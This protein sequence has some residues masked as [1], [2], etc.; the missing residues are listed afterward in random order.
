MK[1]CFLFALIALCV[2]ACH[3]AQQTP[4]D[5]QA[6]FHQIVDAA[7]AH[8]D[9]TT[10]AR[11][12]SL[13]GLR[14]I[15]EAEADFA[16]GLVSDGSRHTQ[17]AERYWTKCY[18][19]L[20]PGRDGWDLYLTVASRLSQIRMSIGDHTGALDVA[21]K[22]LR[23]AEQA[24]TLTTE[25]KCELL[26]S[27]AYCQ[28]NLH[29]DEAEQ[30][31]RQ[32]SEL[33]RQ[34]AEEWGVAAS[35]NELVFTYGFLSD[36]VSER[37]WPRVDSLVARMEALFVLCDSPWD[38]EL[39]EEYRLRLDQ[40]K[41]RILDCQDRPQEAMAL[42]EETLPKMKDWPDGLAWAARYLVSK[43]RYAEA[44]DL[45]D[46]V[47]ALLPD[48]GINNAPTLDN[49]GYHLIP[50]FYANNHAGRKEKALE[51]GERIALH[52]NEALSQ[53]KE[54]NAAELAII[55]DT[56]G[57]EMQI[58]RQRA[59]L[60]QQRLLGL[61]IAL[62]L[63]TAFFLIYSWYRRR[64]QHRLAVA[65]TELQQAYDRLEETTAAKER[66]ESEL[67]IARDIQMSMVPGVF[68][69]TDGLDMYAAMTPAKEVGGDLYG[70]VLQ[71]EQLYFCVGDVSGK[72][73]PASLF[74][75]QAARL[76]R[77]LAAEGLMPAD[78]ATRMNRA[79]SENNDSCMFVTMFIGLLH[80]DSGR[81]DYCNCG[82]N[83]PVLEGAFLRMQYDNQPLGV[84]EEASF[85]GE[86]IP[87]V[88][89][90]RM[91]IYTDGLN[92]AENG[93]HEQLG[94]DRLLVLMAESA[95]LDARRVIARLSEAVERHRAGA[96]P[97]DDLT[98]MCLKLL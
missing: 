12:D 87:D 5:H 54:S 4:E 49:I 84:W 41:I 28:H 93:R 65:H 3:H 43:D 10:L 26:W 56:Q 47:D 30:T 82:H 51:Y 17:A 86:S 62:V 39:V 13:A 33:L 20:N 25:T 8:P 52:Y 74:M 55:Y 66:I 64:A 57:K 67:R 46:R 75:A 19:A 73:V 2:A 1:K 45:Y 98:L 27:I 60:S 79:L 15:S 24:G 29:L 72:G 40:E 83:A 90:R 18:E 44:A 94:N 31:S 96:A 88:R 59:R 14:L 22:T 71:G 85:Q 80:L 23:E 70:Y 32:V 6:Q 7:V 63:L 35:G 95:G 11:I 48:D 76:F 9:E 50:R 42:F 92:E 68:P 77:T 38:K 89:G 61:G 53:S 58:A 16:R 97:N 37:N 36:G 69:E 34:E 78:I 21:T 91:L 81:L